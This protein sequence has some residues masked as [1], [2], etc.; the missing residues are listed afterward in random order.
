VRGAN[1]EILRVL[2]PDNTGS[3]YPPLTEYVKSMA[4]QSN[5]LHT[6]FFGEPFTTSQYSGEFQAD[7]SITLTGTMNEGTGD[8]PAPPIVVPGQELI[9]DIYTGGAAPTTSNGPPS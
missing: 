5:T 7:G 3:A 8:V 6:A 2:S 4:G 1:G 9:E